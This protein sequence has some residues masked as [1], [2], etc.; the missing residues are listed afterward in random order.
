TYLTTHEYRHAQQFHMANQGAVL[1]FK[2]LMGQTGWLL[3]A[4]VNQPLWFREGDAVI[5]ETELTNAGRGRM[6]RF[7]METRAML[8]SGLKYNYEK[9][10]FPASFRDFV[11][12]PYRLGYYLTTHGR[13]KYDPAIWQKVLHRTHHRSPVYA[14]TRSLKDQTGLNTRQLYQETMQELENR[15]QPGQDSLSLTPATVISPPG[16]SNY[17]NYRF[18]HFRPDGSVI[19]LKDGFD[20]IRSFYQILPGGKEEKLVTH[21]VYTEDHI[22]FSSAG[23]L[24]TWAE[25]A[26][27]ERWINQDFSVVKTYHFSTGKVRKITSRSRY[28]AP[29]PSPDGT[30]IVAVEASK[31]NRYN[32]ALL[33]AVSG[34]KLQELPN[35]DNVFL[36]QPRFSQNGENIIA[37]AITAAGNSLIEV[38]AATGIITTLLPFT[39]VPV[40]SPLPHG[41]HIYFAAGF[42]G[43]DNIYALHRPTGKISQITSVPFGAYEPTVSADGKKLLYSSYTA[44]GYRLEETELNPKKWTELPPEQYQSTLFQEFLPEQ[45]KA[46]NLAAAN[47]PAAYQVRKYRAFSDGL[48]NIYGWF[49]SF[50][51]N[52]YGADF[53]TRNLMST[54]RGTI[55][56]FYNTN[57]AAIGSKVNLSYAA[58]YPVID[59]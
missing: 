3:N 43:I 30:R 34:E 51:N 23:D 48:F 27:D 56:V 54:L 45:P 36:A 38:S 44:R 55:G 33:D 16:T 22:M 9:A 18:P 4:L 5:A 15:W 25:S 6:P 1:P 57:E 59:L 12:N 20:Q 28:F 11:P 35:P 2:I 49:P 50:G 37:L 7:H 53:Y 8:L 10:N 39:N 29:A 42:T 46:P 13:R 19:V 21:G 17:T 58:L 47:F 26:F 14:F 31:E 41:E 32:L 24:M 52:Q 40:S